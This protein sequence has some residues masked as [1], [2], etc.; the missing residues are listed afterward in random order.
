MGPTFGPVCRPGSSEMEGKWGGAQ[1]AAIP[2]PANQYA[3]LRSTANIHAGSR[4]PE[5]GRPR[6][7]DASVNARGPLADRELLN[8]KTFLFRQLTPWRAS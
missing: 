1:R 8:F 3:E 4:L 7:T 6:D 5:C 2:S